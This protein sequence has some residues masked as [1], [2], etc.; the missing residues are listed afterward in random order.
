MFILQENDTSFIFDYYDKYLQSYDFY[1]N[2]M[3]EDFRWPVAGLK[4]TAKNLCTGIS[5]IH[6]NMT[7]K[8][9]LA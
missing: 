1:C 6:Q 3:Q 5:S 9:L 7:P 4:N 8:L 2:S